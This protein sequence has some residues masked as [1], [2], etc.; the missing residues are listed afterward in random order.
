[1]STVPCPTTILPRAVAR[2]A[3][4]RTYQVVPEAIPSTVVD[5]VPW[6]PMAAQAVLPSRY[7]GVVSDCEATSL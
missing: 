5:P 4:T 6:S 3:W 2:M 7:E 1:M